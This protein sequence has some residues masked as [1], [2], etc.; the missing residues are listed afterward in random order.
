MIATGLDP[1]MIAANIESA[2][3]R[4]TRA[5]ADYE[6]ASAE[7]AWWLKGAQLAG[8]PVTPEE[9]DPMPHNI[10]E[11]FP[12]ASYFVE[13]GVDPTL[14]QAV[15][16]FLR[17]HAGLAFPVSDIA[18]ALIMRGWL[19]DDDGAQ[20]RVSDISSLMHGDELLYRPERG[21]YRLHPRLAAEF[22]RQQSLGAMGARPYF[23]SAS[24]DAQK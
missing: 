20:K 5:L 22:E 7:L 13:N 17:E 6:T 21:H 14:R 11:L 1:A 9:D 24:T 18:A 16:A 3:A 12:P 19:I 10:A 2:R 15:I 23:P 8:L 4:K